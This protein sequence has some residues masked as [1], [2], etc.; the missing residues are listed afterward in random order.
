MWEPGVQ[1]WGSGVGEEHPEREGDRH[2]RSSLEASREADTPGSKW[3]RS[4][5][6]KSAIFLSEAPYPPAHACF[7][8]PQLL[9]CSCPSA[10][11]LPER[12][13]A[14]SQ[15][16]WQKEGCH[17]AVGTGLS[18]IPESEQLETVAGL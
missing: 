8:V 11:S 7:C 15:H 3:E 5:L 4:Q 16:V 18:L 17:G 1:L 14:S 10:P 2:Y 9:E 13:A 6:E 12:Q